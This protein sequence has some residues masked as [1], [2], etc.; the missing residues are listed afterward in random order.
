[1]STSITK[2]TVT[3]GFKITAIVLGSIAPLSYLIGIKGFGNFIV[4]L[5]IYALHHFFI[6]GVI[7]RF[8]PMFGHAYR[9]VK[10]GNVVCTTA[11]PIWIAVSMIFLY[12]S[13]VFTESEN[14]LSYFSL[15]ATLIIY[16]YI[17]MPIGTDQRITDSV[18][19]VV[20][21][22]VTNVVGKDNP[23]V[24]SIISNVYRCCEDPMEGG[25]HW[26]SAIL[27][28]VAVAFVKFSQRD[29]QSTKVYMDN[30]RCKR[31]KG[32]KFLL[33]RTRWPSDGEPITI[34][35]SGDNFHC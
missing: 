13:I 26:Q 28:K 29:G 31:N 8:R 11:R 10:P 15:R 32:P 21:E 22:R 5:L 20:E 2:P 27:A 19:N 12:F 30:Q 24:E 23:M 7:T 17:R 9:L 33:T 34:E 3:K 16:A 25:E 1:M 35:I 4:V 14:L 6:A 18:T